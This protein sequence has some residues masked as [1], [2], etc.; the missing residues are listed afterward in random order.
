MSSLLDVSRE[1]EDGRMLKPDVDRKPRMK[2][3]GKC[4]RHR[5]ATFLDMAKTRSMILA[6]ERK[7]LILMRNFWRWLGHRNCLEKKVINISRPSHMAIRK[8]SKEL[9]SDRRLIFLHDLHM[10][11]GIQCFLDSLT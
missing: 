2:V 4:K 3:N 8:M 10:L 9:T 6:A 11:S 7:A 5:H 1:M